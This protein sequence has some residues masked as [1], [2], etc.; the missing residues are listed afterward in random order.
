MLQIR[1]DGQDGSDNAETSRG[2]QCLL[3]LGQYY[4]TL[5]NQVLLRL[6][7]AAAHPKC[8]YR[9][10]PLD[11]EEQTRYKFKPKFMPLLQPCPVQEMCPSKYI[12]IVVAATTGPILFQPLLR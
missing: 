2:L 9:K 11:L 6:A 5:T 10:T 8:M 3:L 12:V 4:S 7:A 1:G